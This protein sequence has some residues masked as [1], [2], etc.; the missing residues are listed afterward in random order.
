[1]TVST[2]KTVFL[3]GSCGDS[4]WRWQIA[5]PALDAARITWFDPQIKPVENW[6]DRAAIERVAKD[7]AQIVLIVIDAWTRAIASMGEATELICTGRDVV[8]VVQ[9]IPPGIV[10][11]NELIGER[12]RRD[13][14]RYRAYLRDDLAPRYGASVFATVEEAITE[15][16]ERLNQS[17]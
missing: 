1:M 10:I 13:L 3:G 5:K 16:C 7:E 8:L 12:Q 15:I 11:D 6:G 17:E 2:R 9:H 4:T 14:N